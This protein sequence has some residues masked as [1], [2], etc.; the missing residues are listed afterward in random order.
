MQ[1]PGGVRADELY[2]HPLAAAQRDVRELRA[3]V[4]NHLDL[5][6]QPGLTEVEVDE[7]GRRHLDPLD[8]LRRRQTVHQYTSKVERVG[9]G[10]AG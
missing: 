9:A 1:R 6:R 10:R 2:L 8:G 4:E 3:G 7:A 5:L